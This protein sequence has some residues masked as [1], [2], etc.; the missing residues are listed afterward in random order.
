MSKSPHEETLRFAPPPLRF[1][2]AQWPASLKY[3][4]PLFDEAQARAK[5]APLADL[6]TLLSGDACVD[7]RAIQYEVQRMKECIIQLQDLSFKIVNNISRDNSIATLQQLVWQL[8]ATRYRLGYLDRFRAAKM[9]AEDN[10]PASAKPARPE[11]SNPCA[12]TGRSKGRWLQHLRRLKETALAR[13][14]EFY[15]MPL[16]QWDSGEITPSLAMNVHDDT[17][18][19]SDRLSLVYSNLFKDREKHDGPLEMYATRMEQRI[20]DIGARRS[21]YHVANSIAQ[22]C[23]LLDL[24][25]AIYV[26]IILEQDL[27]AS[28]TP[29]SKFRVDFQEAQK[30]IERIAVTNESK[31]DPNWANERSSSETLSRLAGRREVHA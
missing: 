27:P 11:A 24:V 22:F 29:H 30:A 31:V 23:G 12:R 14:R 15:T 5:F 1:P 2:H 10:A 4:R 21:A 13:A 28:A 9:L 19:T 17:E 26:L 3:L 18:L 7:T 6:K 8:A 20:R 25:T 16:V